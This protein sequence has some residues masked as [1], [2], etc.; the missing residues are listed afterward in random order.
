MLDCCFILGVE[1]NSVTEGGCL[2]RGAF[3]LVAKLLGEYAEKVF[4]N[5]Q[6][7]ARGVAVTR[8]NAAA[9]GTPS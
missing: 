6:Q 7:C 9:F 1:G 4:E 2:V 5:S 8:Q 3:V